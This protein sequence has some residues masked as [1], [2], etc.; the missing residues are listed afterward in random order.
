MFRLVLRA[1]GC[2]TLSM[3]VVTSS[4]AM[5]PPEL[6]RAA[7]RLLET[8]PYSVDGQTFVGRVIYYNAK[9]RWSAWDFKAGTDFTLGATSSNEPGLNVITA[10]TCGSKPFCL[11]LVDS[12]G[13][14]SRHREYGEGRWEQ[15]PSV[16]V[17]NPSFTLNELR[18]SAT[19]DIFIYPYSSDQSDYSVR[20]GYGIPTIRAKQ[21]IITLRVVDA[22]TVPDPVPEKLIF[23]FTRQDDWEICRGYNTTGTTHDG[24]GR[25]SL[26]FALGR[27]HTKGGTGCSS[28]PNASTRQLVLSPADGTLAREMFVR[29][30]VEADLVCVRLDEPVATGL[31]KIVVRSVQIGHIASD[32]DSERAV[33]GA[34]L[35]KGDVI[36][37][38]CGPDECASDGGY[39]HVHLRV[40][41]DDDCRS[42]IPIDIGQSVV[43]Y[44]F[45][46]DGGLYQ[47]RRTIIR[48]KRFKLSGVLPLLQ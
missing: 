29:G 41:N 14:K 47:W 13:L 21:K 39:A 32:Q 15:G 27:G 22:E 10:G 2:V 3:L 34:R 4:K 44:D 25:Y 7:V 20:P 11:G 46:S 1:M 17:F 38:A 8:I 24:V 6:P 18:R 35:K 45:T 19:H 12:T 48:G 33:V 9:N 28:K 26:D 36:G 31:N 30:S 23:P 40:F 5:G 43:G 16:S 37:E 42:L